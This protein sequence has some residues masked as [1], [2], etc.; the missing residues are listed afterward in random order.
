MLLLFKFA[1]LMMKELNTIVPSHPGT[2]M[3]LLPLPYIMKNALIE[4]SVYIDSKNIRCQLI[5][6]QTC[7]QNKIPQKG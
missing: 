1:S 4:R 6:V 5:Q 2:Y 7:S 3:L